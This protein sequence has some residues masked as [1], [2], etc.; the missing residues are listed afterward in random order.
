MAGRSLDLDLIDA[1]SNEGGDATP[2]AAAA[3]ER[4][5]PC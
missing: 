1:A 5:P 4:A 2:A 3:P